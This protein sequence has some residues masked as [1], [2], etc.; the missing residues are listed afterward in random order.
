MDKRFVLEMSHVYKLLVFLHREGESGEEE[1]DYK[2]VG[3]FSSIA[4]I[5]TVLSNG[6]F[7]GEA[8]SELIE[9]GWNIQDHM[10][11][12]DKKRL[13]SDKAIEKACE[14]GGYQMEL[15]GDRCLTVK[16]HKVSVM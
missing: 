3:L 14:K 16:I 1:C 13:C 12:L 2:Q 9:E 8:N 10:V 7:G 15:R 6:D 4:K 5:R 11:P